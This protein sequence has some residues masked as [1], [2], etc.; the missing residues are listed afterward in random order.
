MEGFDKY[1]IDSHHNRE[2]Y[3]ANL[4]A[5]TYTFKI[6]ATNNDQSIAKTE[7]AITIIIE[8]ALWATWWAYLIYTTFILTIIALFANAWKRIRTEKMLARHAAVEME[9]EQRINRM[10]MSFFTNISHEFRTPLTMIAGP[11]YQLCNSADITDEN[12]NL[13]CIVQRSVNRMLRLVNQMMDFHKLENDTLKLKVKHTDIITLL[14]KQSD[15]FR[16]NSEE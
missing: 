5:G 3:Y 1:W 6:K 2:A 13:L 11:V 14:K 4:P 16:I 15:I 7:N 9:Q 10:N 8:P 12:K